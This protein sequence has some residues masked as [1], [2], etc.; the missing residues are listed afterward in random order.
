MPP[1]VIVWGL[2]KKLVIAD[3]I[4]VIAN[5]V[6]ALQ[7]P[8]LLRAVGRRVRVCDSDLRRLLGLHRHRA[9]RGEVV[10]IRS[11][12]ELPAAVPRRPAPPTSGIAGTFRCRRGSA[13]T[14]TSRSAAR[15]AAPGRVA[16]NLM[17]TFLASGIWHGASWNYVLWGAYHGL[18]L[19]S[20]AAAV[21]RVG[22]RCKPA[23]QGSVD[24]KPA[25][26]QMAPAAA[27]DRDV[28]ADVHRLV[29]LPRNGAQSVDRRFRA[30]AVGIDGD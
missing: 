2:F 16:A 11:D 12:Q 1:C 26:P 27:G 9:R 25:S 15:G 19:I 22:V 4:G 28:R 10:R 7:D 21:R 8:G 6:F 5:K 14:S 23:R 3:N 24:S 13:I 18:L 20:R 30:R 17:I 29:D